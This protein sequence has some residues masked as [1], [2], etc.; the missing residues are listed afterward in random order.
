MI[1]NPIETQFTI[2]RDFRT[3]TNFTITTSAAV[4]RSSVQFRTTFTSTSFPWFCLTSLHEKVLWWLKIPKSVVL[5]KPYLPTS[6]RAPK[7]SAFTEPKAATRSPTLSPSWRFYLTMFN[8]C[9]PSTL[10]AKYMS[11][12]NILVTLPTTFKYV[13]YYNIVAMLPCSAGDP[14]V[15]RSMAAKQDGNTTLFEAQLVPL[16][17]VLQQEKFPHFLQLF[18][19]RPNQWY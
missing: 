3:L 1:I 12:Q 5:S 14:S 11:Y 18:L 8:D 9:S 15:T 10:R 13:N 17:S 7:L 6:L 19:T 4:G 2:Q 16:P